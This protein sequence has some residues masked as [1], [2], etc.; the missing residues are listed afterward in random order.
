VQINCLYIEVAP[1]RRG[2]AEALR[3][4][5]GHFP[6]LSLQ[7]PCAPLSPSGSPRVVTAQRPLNAQATVCWRLLEGGNRQNMLLNR[8]RRGITASISSYTLCGLPSSSK[9][10][11]SPL[12]V[13]CCN[14]L[15]RSTGLRRVSELLSARAPLAGCPRRQRRLSCPC[16]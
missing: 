16:P 13:N 12:P 5:C 8:P 7:D 3:T 11:F 15:S 6:S 9:A 14:T 1:D 10:T 4:A 2:Q